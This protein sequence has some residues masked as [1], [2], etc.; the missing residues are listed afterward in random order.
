MRRD[1][2]SKA[3]SHTGEAHCRNAKA[4]WALL[5]PCPPQVIGH[6]PS[7]QHCLPFHLDLVNKLKQEIRDLFL[8]TRM[9]GLIS[10][11]RLLAPY[12]RLLFRFTFSPHILL[13]G[14]QGFCVLLEVGWQAH[15]FRL[16]SFPQS[17][18]CCCCYQSKSL[19]TSVPMNGTSIQWKNHEQNN[20]NTERS[21]HKDSI[22]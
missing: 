19:M 3:D 1:E 16:C 8:C 22:N 21:S 11:Q 6:V 13:V 4:L 14:A 12:S 7:G 18:L 17:C 9:D 20:H 10:T 2:V 5:Y 15:L